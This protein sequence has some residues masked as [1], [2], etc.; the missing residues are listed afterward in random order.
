M[1][2]K[3]HVVTCWGRADRDEPAKGWGRMVLV[4]PKDKKLLQQEYPVDLTESAQ[5]HQRAAIQRFPLTHDGRYFFRIDRRTDEQD[6]WRTVARAPLDVHITWT[7]G[8]D[9]RYEKRRISSGTQ[10]A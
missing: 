8:N 3:F 7:E 10:P 9:G 5:H 4:D 6:R 2:H 1:E